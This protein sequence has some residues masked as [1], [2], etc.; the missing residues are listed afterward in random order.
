V[1]LLSLAGFETADIVPPL[2][3][4]QNVVTPPPMRHVPAFIF[5]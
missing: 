1:N 3:S 5:E 4:N 2:R